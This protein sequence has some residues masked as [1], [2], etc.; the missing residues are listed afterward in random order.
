MIR[1]SLLVV[2][3]RPAA[4]QTKTRLSPPLTGEQAA[5]LYECF[6]KDTLEIIRQ[7]RQKLEITPIIAYLPAGEESYFKS[8]APDFDLL[9]QEGSNLSERLHHATTRC[10]SHGYDQVAIM[11]SDSPTLPADCLVEAFTILDDPATDVSFGMVDDGGYY[12][13]G[14]K[15][16]APDLFLNVTMSTA[17]VA[18]DTLTQASLNQL[19]VRLLPNWYD[20]DYADDLRRLTTE[21][22]TLSP[23]I[24]PHTRAFLTANKL[25][26]E[27]P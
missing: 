17:T 15:R 16:P 25:P 5:A 20:I 24:A 11:D 10:L 27:V 12:L 6:L 9:L 13:I 8:L 2:A 1:R 3:K 19:M 14:L 21:L 26:I 18:Q 22:N 23:D 4:G 7:A